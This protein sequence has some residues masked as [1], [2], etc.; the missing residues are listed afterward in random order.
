MHFCSQCFEAKE[1]YEKLVE[2]I[3]IYIVKH[4]YIDKKNLKSDPRRS[5]TND[6]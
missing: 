3:T 1:S 2:A 4:W 5:A 6:E